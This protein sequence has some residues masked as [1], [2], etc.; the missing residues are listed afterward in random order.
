MASTTLEFI[1]VVIVVIVVIVNFYIIK[2]QTALSMARVS[3]QH[4]KTWA[5]CLYDHY[6]HYDHPPNDAG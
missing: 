4:C 3:L 6:D 2:I 5:I 1:G